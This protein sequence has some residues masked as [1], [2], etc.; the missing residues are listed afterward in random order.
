MRGALLLVE[1]WILDASFTL[2]NCIRGIY[3]ALCD[4][5]PY[6]GGGLAGGLIQQ[7]LT[8]LRRRR[9]GQP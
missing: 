5:A 8:A 6:L 3:H 1:F 9:D 4:A 2:L 7:A